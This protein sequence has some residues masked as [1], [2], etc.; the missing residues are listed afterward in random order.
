MMTLTTEQII[1]VIKQL[2]KDPDFLENE[3]ISDIIETDWD[4]FLSSRRSMYP[5][6]DTQ[7]YQDIDERR[8]HLNSSIVCLIQK[9]SDKQRADKTFDE[10]E[11][12]FTS[13]EA[14]SNDFSFEK[15]I[16]EG[17]ILAFNLFAPRLLDRLD[18]KINIT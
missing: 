3:P 14:N 1:N 11:E 16:V 17:F 9:Q 2:T 6:E 5:P 12:C 10:I 7:K 13:R 15:G 4:H 18:S 8:K